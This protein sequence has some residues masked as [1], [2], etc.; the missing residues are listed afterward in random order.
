MGKSLYSKDQT[1]LANK[2]KEAREKAKL[3]QKAIAKLLGKTQSYISKVE[4]GQRRVD[5]IELQEFSRIYKQ[6]LS[7]FVQEK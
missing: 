7:F 5:V 4:S 2:L 1:N 6:K 3:D